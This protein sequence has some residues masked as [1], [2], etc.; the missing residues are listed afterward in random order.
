MRLPSTILPFA[1]AAAVVATSA[2]AM[3][4]TAAS[5]TD[6]AVREGMTLSS[7]EGRRVGRIVR[8]IPGSNGASVSVI[9]DSRFVMVPV[10]TITAQGRTA[11]T[12]LTWAQL[13]A[14]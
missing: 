10:A 8:V 14:L 4:Q 9:L 11:T 5:A 7:A 13:R 12:S 6:V 3:A 1:L 2:P